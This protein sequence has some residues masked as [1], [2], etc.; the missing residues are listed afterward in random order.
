MPVKITDVLQEIIALASISS[1]ARDTR[2]FQE[3]SVLPNILI[4]NSEQVMRHQVTAHA[5]DARD[6]DNVG[7]HSFWRELKHSRG[8]DHNSRS[9]KVLPDA[10]ISADHLVLQQESIAASCSTLTFITLY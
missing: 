9:S 3:L 4:A 2:A 5:P 10:A 1:R 7:T 6:K 8:N